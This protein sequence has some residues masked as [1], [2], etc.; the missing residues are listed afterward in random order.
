MPPFQFERF[1]APVGTNNG[2]A[3]AIHDGQ[4]ADTLLA[5]AD[6]AMYRAKSAHSEKPCFYDSA[7]D[8]AVRDRRELASDLRAAV[9]AGAFHLHFQVQAGDA[10][11]AARSVRHVQYDLALA[12]D[13]LLKLADLIAGGRVGV[14]VGSHENGVDLC[15]RLKTS[16]G[17]LLK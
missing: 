6:L 13:R 10:D 14:E 9:Q 15:G 12:H 5:R 17:H 4:D 8:D 16:C 7:M 2:V 11:R 1:T 3:L